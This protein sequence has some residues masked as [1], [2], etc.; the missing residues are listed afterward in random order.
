MGSESVLLA[1]D[2][3]HDVLGTLE[4]DLTRRFAADYRIV[5]ADHSEAALAEL[6]V[7]DDVALVIAGQWLTGTT[8]IDSAAAPPQLQAL[9][10]R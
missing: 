9:N 1:V 10:R 2:S 8:G 5:T 4:R 7:D 6:D 3:D